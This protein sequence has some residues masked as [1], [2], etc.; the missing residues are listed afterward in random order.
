LEVIRVTKES[1]SFS[2]DE[3][4]ILNLRNEGNRVVWDDKNANQVVKDVPLDRYITALFRTK[5]SELQE[6]EELTEQTR[7]LY[8]KFILTFK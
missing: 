4:E 7:S 2:P 1:L 8:E 3:I 5:I 6:K